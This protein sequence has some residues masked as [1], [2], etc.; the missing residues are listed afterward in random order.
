ML[1]RSR[2]G[3]TKINMATAEKE[4][5]QFVPL[6]S[7][8]DAGFWHEL[9]RRKLDKYHLSEAAQYISGYYTNSRLHTPESQTCC[10]GFLSSISLTSAHL[11]SR[12]H[13]SRGSGLASQ[14]FL[15]LSL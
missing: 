6:V 1:R 14:P 4:V 13:T 11:V 10:W 5:V 7:R 3:Y 2:W 8:L 9:S 15:L 12:V